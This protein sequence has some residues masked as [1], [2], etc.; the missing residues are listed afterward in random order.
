MEYFGTIRAPSELILGN[1]QRRALG[2]VAKGLGRRALVVTDQRLAA[3]ADFHA[4]TADLKSNG[5]T[6]QIESGTLPDVPAESTVVAADAARAFAPDL[7]IGIGGGSCLDM[8]KCVALLLTHGG[9][10]EDYYGELKVPGPILPLIAVPTTAG[11]G[12]EVTP[13][14]VLSDSKRSLKIGISSPHLIPR[15]A[16][17]DP[18]L[19]LSCPP[20]LTAIAGAD[21]MTHAIEAFTATRRPIT[22]ALTQERVFIGK[23]ALSDQ[24]ALTAISLLWQGLETAC[25]EGDNLAA[26]A[27]VMQGATFAGLAFGVAGTAAAHAIQ[28][29]VGALTHTAHGAGVACLMPWV[30]EW[31]RPAIGAELEKM[32]S[33][34]GL[35]DGAAV[36]PAISSLFARIGIPPTLALLGLAEERLDWVAEQSCG[37]ERLIQNNP[38]PLDR[39][40]MRKL[41]DAAFSG[42]VGMMQ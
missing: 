18:E 23:N 10:P 38:R 25:T 35:A 28:Y 39:S 15:A 24:F 17:C 41:L 31:N 19:T 32:A 12:S 16:I 3:D 40:D 8:A 11:T 36:I 20:A 30:M 29:P 4:M 7:V 9:R 37:I 26:R 14:A 33:A 5:L 2:L 22:P 27:Q 42:D 1:G 13:V 6:V 21:A 34:M